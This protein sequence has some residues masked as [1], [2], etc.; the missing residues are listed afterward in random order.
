MG[1]KN[2][3]LGRGAKRELLTMART[4]VTGQPS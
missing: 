3:P 1:F 2:A 4:I